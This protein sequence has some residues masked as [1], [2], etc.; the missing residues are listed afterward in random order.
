MTEA[1][2]QIAKA[3][4]IEDYARNEEKIALIRSEL[5]SVGRNLQQLAIALIDT[6][7][8]V[9]AETDDLTVS[10][11]EGYTNRPADII[12]VDGAWLHER[13][14][15]LQDAMRD[16][17]RMESCLKQAG[18]ETLIKPLPQDSRRR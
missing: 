16:K 14:A 1:E 3:R 5:G 7:L 6:P 9:S 8:N 4:L 18:L 15:E 11:D 13:V 2:R 17:T 10:V 12:K